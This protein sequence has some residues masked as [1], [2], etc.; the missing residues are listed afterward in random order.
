MQELTQKT[1]LEL[2]ELFLNKE[3]SAQEINQ[4]FL[5]RIEKYDQGKNGINAFISSCKDLSTQQ[6]AELD[7]RLAAGEELGILAGVP[8]AVKDLIN[9]IGSETTAASKML[10]GYK[11]TFNATISEKVLAAG[12]LTV[13]KANLD[14]FAMG[15]SNETSAYG[16]VKNP[17]D[18]RRVPGGS[19]GGSA[20]AVAAELAPLAFG[21]D[22]GGSIR[23]PASYCGIVGLKPTYGRVSRYGIVAFASSLDQAGPMAKTVKDTALLMQAMAGYD[24]KDSTS[25]NV[26]VPDYLAAIENGFAKSQSLK[27]KKIGIAPEFF[28]EGLDP[29]VKEA[30][31]KAIK[32]F[33]SLGAE[34]VDVSFDKTKYGLPCYYVIAPSEAS[35]NLSRYDGV[36]FG[37]RDT[38]ADNL[39]DL[40]FNSRSEF[41]AEVKRRI[42]IGVHALS[43][44]YYDAYYKKAQ[45]VRRLIAEDYAKAF[46]KCDFVIS[47]STPAPAFIS[48][49]V[50]D[51][52]SMY[53]ADIYTVQVNLAGL[54]AISQ[55][56]GFTKEGMPIGMQ[57][58]APAL[59]EADLL[60]MAYAFESTTDF[61]RKPDLDKNLAVA[62]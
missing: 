60:D 24:P 48:D 10:K 19:S 16:K 12:A 7:Q 44:G 31:E 21:T 55:N 29:E 1:A 53:L 18:Y 62:S 5:E 22:T 51:P 3:A 28:G 61:L 34:M 41:G 9:L 57:L 37:H 50:Q 33:E 32:H 43:S 20:A 17:W 30:V 14:E 8:L 59:K 6:A 27:G 39:N 49:S 58:I 4:A 23:Q 52:L 15:S 36:R 38:E 40:Y 2:K 11:S 42:M 35:S 56:C 47:P 13:G 26:E 54:P 25:I 46:S 45:Q